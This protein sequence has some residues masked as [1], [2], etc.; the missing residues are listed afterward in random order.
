ME[1]KKLRRKDGGKLSKLVASSTSP[2][3]NEAETTSTS[4]PK[5]E[6]QTIFKSHEPLAA[7][8]VTPKRSKM[9]RPWINKNGSPIMPLQRSSKPREEFRDIITPPST[10]PI[11]GPSN[12]NARYWA[13]IAVSKRNRSVRKPPRGLSTEGRDLEKENELSGRSFYR[14][15]ENR[16]R[17]TGDDPLR[18]ETG[19]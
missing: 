17:A 9:P 4:L 1:S 7:L 8:P 3:K 12:P 18:G 10:R 6:R 16:I 11:F 2:P 19:I 14:D 13:A 5:N 15:D